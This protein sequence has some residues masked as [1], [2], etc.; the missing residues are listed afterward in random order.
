M[1]LEVIRP[2]KNKCE[3]RM[4]AKISWIQVC[5]NVE[6]RGLY[7]ILPVICCFDGRYLPLVDVEVP[8]LGEGQA[9]HLE[10]DAFNR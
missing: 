8:V 10:T 4:E 1:L 3:P 7:T 9:V 2:L 6:N 5:N